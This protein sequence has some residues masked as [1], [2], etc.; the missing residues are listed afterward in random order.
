MFSPPLHPVERLLTG[1]ALA[2]LASCA[3]AAA[4]DFALRVADGDRALVDSFLPPADS[5]GGIKGGFY[6][7][8]DAT[9]TYDSNFFILQDYPESEFSVDIAPWVMYRTD[10]EGGARL[11]F[12]ARY[13]PVVHTYWNNS[14]LNGVDHTGEFFF[15][16]NGARTD[17]TAFA[18]YEEV[19]AADR[20]AGGFIQGSILNYGIKGSYQLAPRTSLLGAWTA[21]KSEYDSGGRAGADVYT[22]QISGLWD[23]TERIRIGPAIRHTLTESD[24]TGERDAIAA[25]VRT[26]YQWGERFFFDASGGVEFAKNSRLG[27]GRDAGFTGGLEAQYVLNERWTWKAAIRYANVPSPVNLNYLVDDL[28]FSTSLTR[29]FE[30]GSLEGGVGISFSE[31]EPVGLTVAA[32]EDDEFLNAYLTYRRKLYSDRMIWETSLRG[33]VNEGQKDWSQWQIST[34]IGFQY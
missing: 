9:A 13:S 19:S 32:R 29:F 24:Q 12:E 33:A 18:S 20:L 14:H 21:S 22:A 6:F 10:P 5:L 25:L 8:L 30:R 16:Y 4:Q 17:I 27:G 31:Y 26:R 2:L 3:P 7:G 23:A 1:S 15:R 34:G 11:S 28:S